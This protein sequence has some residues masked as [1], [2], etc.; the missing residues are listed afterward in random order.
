MQKTSS[1]SRPVFHPRPL[2]TD[3]SALSSVLHLSCPP[4][5]NPRFVFSIPKMDCNPPLAKR[6]RFEQ[7]SLDFEKALAMFGQ[8]AARSLLGEASERRTTS[9]TLPD[10]SGNNI[11]N[12]GVTARRAEPTASSAPT[13][14]G[15]GPMPME[16]DAESPRSRPQLHGP[17]PCPP[18]HGTGMSIPAFW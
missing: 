15:P 16:I 12:V 2:S 14:Q 7:T 1:L 4:I 11:F 8:A 3:D 17:R 5:W 10:V 18:R 9:N 6:P 13:G